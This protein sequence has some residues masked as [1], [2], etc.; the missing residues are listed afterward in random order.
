M[1]VKFLALKK[2]Y[3]FTK[4]CVFEGNST[5]IKMS[6][7]LPFR[8]LRSESES[9]SVVPDFLRLH[10]LYSPWNSAGQNTEVGSLSLLQGISQPRGQS[11][12][13]HIAG[14]FS[15]SW[16]TGKPKYT[17]VGSLSLL[18]WIFLTQVFN[19]GFLHCRWIL[20]PLSYQESPKSG[21][22]ENILKKSTK[23]AMNL[24]L[25]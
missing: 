16:A 19:R 25:P 12:V 20:Y 7:F 22:L 23:F 8:Q 4:V 15:T 10:G 5:D 9:H 24:K 18:Q 13:S 21:S 3:H 17:G 2:Y 14:R 11:R 1:N 6:Q